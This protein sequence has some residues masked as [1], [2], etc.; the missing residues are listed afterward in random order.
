MSIIYTP[1]KSCLTPYICVNRSYKAY[2]QPIEQGFV[3]IQKTKNTT[4]SPCNAF[5]AFPF[6]LAHKISTQIC[7][8]VLSAHILIIEKKQGDLSPKRELRAQ[9]LRRKIQSWHLFTVGKGILA[10]TS[11][12]ASPQPVRKRHQQ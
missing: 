1:V 3:I 8:A 4:T 5:V 12:L 10:V 9:K 7:E 2:V 6:I 11:V